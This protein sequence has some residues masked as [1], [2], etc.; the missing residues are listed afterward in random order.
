MDLYIGGVTLE[1]SPIG[2]VCAPA[3]IRTRRSLEVRLR[4]GRAD[5]LYLPNA[6]IAR[7]DRRTSGAKKAR[8][9]GHVG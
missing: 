9:R 1:P 8:D 7:R 5:I 3:Y 2:D 6:R 4:R